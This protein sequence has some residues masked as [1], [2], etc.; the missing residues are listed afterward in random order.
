MK[1]ATLCAL[2]GLAILASHAVAQED[3]H[4]VQPERPTVATHAGTVAAGWFEIETGL[5]RD[6]VGSGASLLTPTVLKFGIGSHAQLSIAGSVPRPNASSFGIGDLAV[7]IKWRLVDDAPVLG[8]FALLPSVK[9]ATGAAE[10]GRGT[11]TTDVSL[12]AISSHE[13]G[14]VA[15]DLNVGYT[16]RSGDG[17]QAPK[18]A[19]VW[20]ASFGRPLLSSL[21]WTAEVYG[22][23]TT[24]GPAGQSSIVG[25]LVGPTFLVREYLAVDAGLIVP[26]AGPQPHALYAGGVWNVGKLR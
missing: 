21:G 26:V 15:M 11:G 14:P 16:R 8:D 22:F 18:N 10:K 2:T 13:F 23:P 1:R 17:S 4:A 3:P 9:F 6:R 20:T 24:T 19:T 7:G 5:E 25:F 12:L